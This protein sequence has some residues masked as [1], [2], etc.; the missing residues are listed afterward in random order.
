MNTKKICFP[1]IIGPMFR[2]VYL[3]TLL[4]VALLVSPMVAYGAT[5][6]LAWDAN[7]ETDLAG[8]KIYY[9]TG[10]GDY[11]EPID[12]GNTTQY[13]HTGFA[14]GVTYYI[15]VT[16]YDVDNNESAYSAELVHTIAT[17]NNDPATPSVPNSPSSGYTQTNYTFSTTASD[18]DGDTL[19]FQYDWDDASI[20]DWGA[21]S[22]S[23][24]WSSA[25]IFCVKAQAKDS[26]GALSEWSDCRNITITEN[27]HT[28]AA[29][30]GA[31]GSILPSGNVTVNHGSSRTFTI[32]A[33]TNYHIHDVLVDEVSV[34]AVTTHIFN[35]VSDD[36]T[37]SVIFA[38]DNQPPAADA[39][40]GG[41]CK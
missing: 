22:Q 12:V 23:H 29:T 5:V 6:T 40:A 8:Y 24:V 21:S 26:N 39:G 7:T 36:H 16:A 13:T 20:S 30:A 35:N 28:I 19:Q 11:L 3:L 27:T 25:G 38:I 17:A 14:E 10:S 15:A 4:A 34:G 41:V 37:I 18:P 9:G 32:S 33:D 2:K 1:R 31:N